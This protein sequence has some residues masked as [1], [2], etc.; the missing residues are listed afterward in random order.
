MGNRPPKKGNTLSDLLD[1]A[2]RDKISALKGG[3]PAG[4]QPATI[5]VDTPKGLADACRTYFSKGSICIDFEFDDNRYSYGRTLALAQVYDGA[6]TYLIDTLALKDLSPLTEVLASEQVVKIFHSCSSD[7]SIMLEVYGCRIRNIRDTSLAYTLLLESK[8][9]I[10]LSN[11]VKEKLGVQLEKDEQASNWLVRPLTPTQLAYAANDVLYLPEIHAMLL[12]ELAQKGRDA[13]YRQEC[14]ELEKTTLANKDA[15]LALA[16][17][18][19]LNP[20]KSLLLQSYWKLADSLASKLNLP[21]YKV[22][23]GP[24]LVELALSPPASVEAW[25]QIRGCHPAAKKEMWAAKFHEATLQAKAHAQEQIRQAAFQYFLTRDLKTEAGLHYGYLAKQ[26][27]SLFEKLR[28]LTANY[29][30]LDLQTLILT[31]KNRPQVI[32][33]GT[34]TLTPW[35]QEI[36]A[37]LAND[38]DIDLTPLSFMLA[39]NPG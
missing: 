2:Q 8:N 31:N 12:D 18:H 23:P 29:K 30:G 35:K 15:S 33:M 3:K 22:I 32:W 7:L 37:E 27:E 38:N 39:A 17:K 26:R 24:L 21:H 4:N 36:L 34:G 13:W 6:D 25:Q 19:R 20:V 9:N 28:N 10:S 14:V 1:Q 11:L 16:R 5:W